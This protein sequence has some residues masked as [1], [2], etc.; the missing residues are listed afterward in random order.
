M[1]KRLLVS[2]LIGL[3][4]LAM[5]GQD[6]SSTPIPAYPG[7]G[8]VWKLQNQHS[9]D[10]NYQGKNNKFYK[11]W[12][13]RYFNAW[14]GPGLSNFSSAN[15]H[16]ADGNLI[17][18]A[19]PN[20]K[21]RVYC[22]VV[23]SKTKVK[24]PIYM[25]ARLQTMNQTLS[26]NFWMLSQN[27]RQELDAVE[28]YGSD[29]SS[30]GDEH[31]FDS[32][33]MNSNYHIF[34]RNANDNT[35]IND[36]TWQRDHYVTD[37]QPLKNRP[38]LRN[39]FHNYAIHW[40]DEWN[41][42]W[43]LDGKLV[44]RIAP[45]TNDV[46]KDPLQNKGIYE[47]MF[48][49]LDVEDHS[50][51]SD[52]GHIATVKELNDESKNKMYVDWV[53]VYK[54]VNGQGTP[55]PKN[56][57]SSTKVPVKG[58]TVTPIEISM[59]TGE[60]K[61]VGG[62]V[63]PAF[64]TDQ[65]VSFASSNPAVAT[66][67][68]NGAII[69]V[70]Q[71]TATIWGKT[72]DGGYVGQC[73]VRVK[74]SNKP[75]VAVTGVTITPA[76]VQIGVGGTR[77]LAGRVT[78][79]EATDKSV[80]FVSQ[81]TSIAT[82]NQLGIVTG[83]NPGK[84]TITVTAI[85]GFFTVAA[86]ITVTGKA[87]INTPVVAAP[88]PANAIPV[89]GIALTPKNLSI[90]IGSIKQLAGR[91]SPA[92]ATD[93]TMVFTSSNPAVASVNQA[94]QVKALKRGVVTITAT[95][96]DGNFK[97]SATITSVILDTTAP[98][99]VVN[100]TKVSAVVL[101]PAK[102][103]IAVGQTKQLAG[104]VQPNTAKDKRV[105]FT[106][107]NTS[108]ATVNQLGEVTGIKN[109]TVII[110]ATSMDGGFTDTSNVTI[111]KASPN[112]GA[113]VVPNNPTTVNTNANIYYLQNR[114]TGKKVGVI[115]DA[116]GALVVQTPSNTTNTK[117]QWKK[118]DLSNGYFYLQNVS[119]GKNFIPFNEFS[120]SWLKQENN[121]GDIAQWKIVNA[122][123]GFFYLENKE[124]DMYIR[125]R[126]KD[127]T[128]ANTGSTYQIEQRPTSFNGFWTQWAFIPV[129]SGAK[130]IIDQNSDAVILYPNPANEV[131]SVK[132]NDLFS[133]AVARISLIDINGA[134]ISTQNF[135][136]GTDKFDV[137]NLTAGVYFVV[138]R[139]NERKLSK[140]LIIE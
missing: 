92:N 66:V 31:V 98:S 19:S 119:S 130:N 28:S 64:A 72:T 18:K 15:S 107:S 110:T 139:T 58:I 124:S 56:I 4:S 8:K 36:N 81:N 49:I 80:Y 41:V 67:D 133:D 1:K 71:G 78:P 37:H 29:R 108:I 60:K 95:S 102:L 30:F 55:A 120:G 13:D 96:T 42:D 44:R 45:G 69:G 20:G 40:I 117:S 33:H 103:N 122:T 123:D 126:T 114:L 16:V 125:P 59:L 53:R 25:E 47:E 105:L 62:A 3:A 109:G 21:N 121:S 76:N 14:T 10:F 12:N 79:T 61:F 127:D 132:L 86:D 129:N 22:G 23:T 89:K 93:N 11:N 134:V 39:G 115:N 35:I 6:W 128:G 38:A 70:S 135:T 104:K 43:Y 87:V 65:T 54:P 34:D 137:S 94:G 90:Q 57:F 73:Q 68:N 48:L 100:N 46:I 111:G 24:F 91:V 32:R 138:I 5:N 99:P 116:K 63:I 88:K 51:R 52:A 75:Q 26:S 118:I 101:T 77:Q 106:S 7:P 17:I 27:D 131:V 112:T 82:V 50:W 85:D 2:S 140:K 9:D 97:D 136:N 84:T 83:I 113:N 74:Q